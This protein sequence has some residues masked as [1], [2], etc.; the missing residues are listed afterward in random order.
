MKQAS[1]EHKIPDWTNSQNICIFTTLFFFFFLTINE[2][3]RM[4]GTVQIKQKVYIVV[5]GMC[6]TLECKDSMD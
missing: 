1:T 6:D 4:S 3:H 5:N 2:I